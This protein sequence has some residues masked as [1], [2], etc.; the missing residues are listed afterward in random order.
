IPA[1][2]L[3][4]VRDDYR[5][6]F[7]PQMQKLHLARPRFED[8]VPFT[9]A[10]FQ[11]QYAYIVKNPYPPEHRRDLDGSGRDDDYS[12]VHA[13]YHRSFRRIVEKFG[14]YDL[15]LIDYDTCHVLYDV[16]KDRDFGT[17]LRDGPYRDSNLAKLV[18]RCRAT[19]NPDDVFFS[20]FEP[21]EAS[22]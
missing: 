3:Y 11:L 5:T 10:A 17:S 19:N 12:R 4:A 18:Q 13:K 15:Y 2:I 20:D 9:P 8:Y 7:Y 21:Y 22:S 1:E 14:Y 6:H 16:N